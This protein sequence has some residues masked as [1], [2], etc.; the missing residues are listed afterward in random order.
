MNGD[1]ARRLE[2]V[3]AESHI[4]ARGWLA[5]IDKRVKRVRNMDDVADSTFNIQCLAPDIQHSMQTPRS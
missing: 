1:E 4:I 5:G 3:L 2:V